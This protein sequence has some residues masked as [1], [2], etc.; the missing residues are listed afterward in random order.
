MT[1]DHVDVVLGLPVGYVDA[2]MTAWRTR[3]AAQALD[4][5]EN[6]AFEVLADELTQQVNAGLA[7]DPAALYSQFARQ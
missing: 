1:A 7:A 2:E 4:G 5:I 3:V 6:D